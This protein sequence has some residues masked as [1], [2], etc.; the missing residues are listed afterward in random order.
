MLE[1][2]FVGVFGSNPL[3]KT[4]FLESVAKKNESQGM[5]IYLRTER[6]T[7]YS[8]LDDLTYPEKIQGYLRIASL[9]DFAYYLVSG[10]EKLTA[11][12]GELALLLDSFSLQGKIEIIDSPSVSTSTN[13]VKSA[14]RGTKLENY[15]V[16][17]RDSKSSILDLSDQIQRNVWKEQQ[18]GAL[19]FVDRAFNVK[20]VGLVVLGF[21]LFGHLAIHDLLK[22][23]SSFGERKAEVKGIQINDVDFDS[24]GR[25][26]R[27]GL[28]LKGVE[29]SDLEKCRWLYGGEIQRTSQLSINFRRSP[30]YKKDIFDRDIHLAYCGD[31]FPVH[32]THSHGEQ[33]ILAN[34]AVEVPLIEGLETCLVDLNAK[35]PRIV[36]GGTISKSEK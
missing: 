14:L 10:Q 17:G 8:F 31:T 13:Q 24:A 6:E 33:K 28:S 27:V 7:R 1:G 30:F 35:I 3:A 15:A 4:S 26:L 20:G 25:G 9:C 12:D 23:L 11:A 18:S 5:R 21:I 36:G 16:E 22:P 34:L 29:L 19:V 32:V 2:L